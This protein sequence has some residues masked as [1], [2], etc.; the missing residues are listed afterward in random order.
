MFSLHDA[1]PSYKVFQYAV[2]IVSIAAW[3]RLRP[4]SLPFVP[5]GELR[6][7][8]Y[9]DWSGR[10]RD[11]RDHQFPLQGEAFD[12]PRDETGNRRRA[13]R[14]DAARMALC[15]TALHPT[16][17][18]RPEP[19]QQPDTPTRKGPQDLAPDP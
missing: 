7:L 3:A 16:L 8:P 1:L 5:R 15:N 6:D 18:F 4:S 11:R 19:R 12:R 2:C 17:L 9:L 10:S 13:L 14:Q